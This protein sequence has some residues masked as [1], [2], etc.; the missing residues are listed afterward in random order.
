VE[1]L[2]RFA[3]YRNIHGRI[4]IDFPHLPVAFLSQATTRITLWPLVL[5][6]CHHE[7]M[8][9]YRIELSV[10]KMKRSRKPPGKYLPYTK[11]AER[12]A[13]EKQTLKKKNPI[14][15]SASHNLLHIYTFLAQLG[16][17]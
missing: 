8:K 11:T 9:R 7:W 13:E 16:G 15:H 14:Y 5:S 3:L 1:S 2:L 6:L 4:L 17:K 12:R 10:G